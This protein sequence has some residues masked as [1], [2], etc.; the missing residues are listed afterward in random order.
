[1]QK[2][3]K[4]G[5]SRE[6]RL[7]LT[8]LSEKLAAS[9]ADAAKDEGQERHADAHAPAQDGPQLPAPDRRLGGQ[10]HD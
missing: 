10:I 6:G 8:K 5:L 9:L 4:Y 1:M 2:K 7:T 3:K